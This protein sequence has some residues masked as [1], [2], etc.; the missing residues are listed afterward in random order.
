MLLLFLVINFGCNNLFG[1]Q[2]FILRDLYSSLGLQLIL[3][4]LLTLL[5][6]PRRDGL[7]HI[8][9]SLSHRSTNLAH[10]TFSDECEL[11]V[12]DPLAWV[13]KATHSR[14]TLLAA[15]LVLEGPVNKQAPLASEVQSPCSVLISDNKELVEPVFTDAVPR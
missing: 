10:V 12:L 8:S 1:L 13:L 14:Q 4:L 2:I 7:F 3:F 6:L 11:L 9:C 5:L 15:D